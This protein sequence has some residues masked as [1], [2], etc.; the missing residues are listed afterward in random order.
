MGTLGGNGLVVVAVVSDATTEEQSLYQQRP[1]KLCKRALD[2]QQLLAIKGS[3]KS[4]ERQDSTPR[5]GLLK[6]ASIPP[7]Y[8][9]HVEVVQISSA[10]GSGKTF[11]WKRRDSSKSKRRLTHACNHCRACTRA[12]DCQTKGARRKNVQNPASRRK[13]GVL[14]RPPQAN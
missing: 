2:D 13:C 1:G 11:T 12:S 9:E 8:K 10:N 4:A 14:P 7:P 3:K 5:G 6:M